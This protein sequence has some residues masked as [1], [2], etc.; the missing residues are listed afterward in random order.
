[1]LLELLIVAQL[2]KKFAAV[3]ELWTFSPFSQQHT[4]GPCYRS[5]EPTHSPTRYFLNPGVCLNYFFYIRSVLIKIGDHMYSVNATKA[6]ACLSVCKFIRYL[7]NINFHIQS[8]ITSCIY[9][10]IIYYAQPVSVS[11][12]DH[13]QALFQT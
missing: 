1:M 10:Y 4:D 11:L 13:L 9:I 2:V 7:Q 12:L 6:L 8:N 3:Y 5:D